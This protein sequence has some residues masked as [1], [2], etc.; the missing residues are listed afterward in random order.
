MSIKLIL[1]C[2]ETNYVFIMYVFFIVKINHTGMW[3][4]ILSL[5]LISFYNKYVTNKYDS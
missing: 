4:F 5:V 2:F 3:F 1:G